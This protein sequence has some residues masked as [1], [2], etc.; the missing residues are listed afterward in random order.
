MNDVQQLPPAKTNGEHGKRRRLT[1][2]IK[3]CLGIA[4]LLV[5]LWWIGVFG[6][7][8]RVVTPGV[9]YR[10]AQLT[11]NNYTADTARWFGHGFRQT[12]KKYHIKTVI[13]LRGGGMSNDYYRDEVR[14][15]QALGAVHVDIPMSA[16]HLPPPSSLKKLI[17]VF[18]RD[19]YPMIFHCQGGSDR[20]G[21][22][23]TLFLAMKEKVPLNQAE[24]QQLTMRY[25]HFGFT[26]TGAMNRFFDLYRQTA[27]GMAIRQ[28]ILLEYPSVYLKTTHSPDANGPTD[29]PASSASKQ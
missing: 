14:E 9:M 18:D 3:I 12:L 6:G 27:H 2:A 20:S 25:G 5:L 16:R 4:A 22:V 11:G 13:N 8:V 1:R 29:Q 23:G 26:S 15:T 10:S 17:H 21:L 24:D 19:P 28:W 7:N